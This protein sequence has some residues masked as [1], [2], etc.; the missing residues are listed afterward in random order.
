MSPGPPSPSHHPPSTPDRPSHRPSPTR[1]TPSR[2]TPSRCTSPPA[3]IVSPPR[4]EGEADPAVHTSNPALATDIPRIVFGYSSEDEQ[5]REREEGDEESEG[6]GETIVRI[7][8]KYQRMSAEG[9][10]GK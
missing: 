9:G 1:S 3:T 5:D 6:E 10:A 4:E 2:Y 7:H 8:A